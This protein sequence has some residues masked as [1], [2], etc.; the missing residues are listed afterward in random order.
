MVDV[1]VEDCGGKEIC[2]GAM[3]VLVQEI[4]RFSEDH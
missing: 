1:V 3:R 4:D 2:S